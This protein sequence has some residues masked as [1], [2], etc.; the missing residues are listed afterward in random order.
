MMI[1]SSAIL[2]AELFSLDDMRKVFLW[3]FFAVLIIMGACFSHDA[4][5]TTTSVMLSI[6]WSFFST[7]VS[8]ARNAPKFRNNIRPV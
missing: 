7:S 8:V 3:Y 6:F 1:L 2:R 5:R 4:E